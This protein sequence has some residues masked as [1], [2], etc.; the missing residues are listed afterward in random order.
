MEWN[1]VH[2]LEEP[3]IGCPFLRT[4]LF[5]A[6][7]KV[8]PKNRQV[9]HFHVTRSPAS[10]K[11]FFILPFEVSNCSYS[12][13]GSNP[14]PFLFKPTRSPFA[15]EQVHVCDTRER[16]L[17][18]QWR[19]ETRK[20][21]IGC[22]LGRCWNVCTEVDLHLRCLGRARRWLVHSHTFKGPTKRRKSWCEAKTKWM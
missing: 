8:P 22:R 10:P 12:I 3:S 17:A 7:S 2:V 4:R 14:K 11:P 1:V 16:R 21:C 19:L 15:L 9:L 13:L 5:F 6:F 18:H 20:S